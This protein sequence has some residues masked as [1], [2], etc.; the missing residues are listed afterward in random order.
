VGGAG[1]GPEKVLRLISGAAATPV[2]QFVDS[3]RTF[4]HAVDPRV[5][6][7]TE[8]HVFPRHAFWIELSSSRLDEE[9]AR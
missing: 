1:A 2:C 5:K 7:V 9:D 3:P 6:L 4:L 8:R